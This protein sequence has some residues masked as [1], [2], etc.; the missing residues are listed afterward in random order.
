MKF[1]KV[2]IEKNLNDMLQSKKNVVRYCGFVFWANAYTR[3]IYALSEEAYDNGV[4]DGY[5][6]GEIGEDYKTVKKV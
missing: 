4:I 3:E 6:V 2:L 5:K 1:P